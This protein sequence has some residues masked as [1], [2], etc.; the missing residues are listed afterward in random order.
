MTQLKIE[1]FYNKSSKKSYSFENHFEDRNMETETG[2]STIQDFKMKNLSNNS[3]YSDDSQHLKRNSTFT[4]PD[5]RPISE[6]VVANTADFSGLVPRHEMVMTA[7]RGQ[8]VFQKHFGL[9]DSKQK[10]R[11]NYETGTS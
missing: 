10:N 11:F 5:N 9:S 7:R 1:D 4:A 6:F 2:F 8:I 3:R